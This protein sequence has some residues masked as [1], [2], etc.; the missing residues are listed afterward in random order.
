MDDAE[1]FCLCLG[2]SLQYD[3]YYLFCGDISTQLDLQSTFRSRRLGDCD[4]APA[5]AHAA[6]PA[7]VCGAAGVGSPRASLPAHRRGAHRRGMR[8]HGWRG[9]AHERACAPTADRPSNRAGHRCGWPPSRR[10]A[11]TDAR[12][13]T[14]R[15][16]SLPSSL[17]PPQRA[18]R[19]AVGG[20]ARRAHCCSSGWSLIMSSMRSTVMAA[21]VANWIIL[22]LDSA[23]SMMPICRLFWILPEM[24]SMP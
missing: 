1:E 10:V 23:G 21:S 12:H 9:S 24:Q 11:L 5:M 7:G 8:E 20:R 3:Y 13:A 22:T 18:E 15:P 4:W 16:H 19:A 2:G 17:L 14:R 6:L